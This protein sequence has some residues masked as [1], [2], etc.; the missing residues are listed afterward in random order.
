MTKELEEKIAAAKLKLDQSSQR[1][2]RSLG[3]QFLSEIIAGLLVGGGFGWFMDDW[4]GTQPW[5]FVVFIVL[6]MVAAFWN[7][8]RLASKDEIG[9]TGRD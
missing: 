9:H 1:A 7:M 3:W 5:L 2:E 8:F 6:G 4:L